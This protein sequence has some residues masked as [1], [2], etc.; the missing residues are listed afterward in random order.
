MAEQGLLRPTHKPSTS[1]SS[2]LL[3]TRRPSSTSLSPRPSRGHHKLKRPYPLAILSIIDLALI[4]H[5]AQ[6]SQ[7]IIGLVRFA[8]IAGLVG[9]SRGWRARHGAVLF[10]S[11]GSLVFVLWET[12]QAVMAGE[13]DWKSPA[14]I[15]VGLQG[16]DKAS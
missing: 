16:T 11:L 2:Y 14:L 4:L 6:G 7:R 3:I 9:C 13:R 12:C 8:T 1:A 10:V 5:Y 15:I